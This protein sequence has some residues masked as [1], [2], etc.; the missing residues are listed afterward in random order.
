MY[1][2]WISRGRLAQQ[3]APPQQIQKQGRGD[4]FCRLIDGMSLT[5]FV[6]SVHDAGPGGLEN[7]IGPSRKSFPTIITL[8]Y[9]TLDWM[10]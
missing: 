10:N 5:Y 3:T 2:S 1:A 7:H 6:S 8:H 9:K 4:D